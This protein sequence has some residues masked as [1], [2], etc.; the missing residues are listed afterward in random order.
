MTE[1]AGLLTPDAIEYDRR[2]G[3]VEMSARIGAL[4]VHAAAAAGVSRGD[5]QRA[6]GFDPA[7][8]ADPD[9]RI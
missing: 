6:T 5:L 1:G 2:M 7:T 9:A 3:S 8:A 4:I